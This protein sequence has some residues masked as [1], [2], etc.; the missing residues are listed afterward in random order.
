M[1][2]NCTGIWTPKIWL[3]VLQVAER[4][5]R[6]KDGN[7]CVDYQRDLPLIIVRHKLSLLSRFWAQWL[8]IIC[9]TRWFKY[10]RDWFVCKQAALVPV[11]FEPPC[12]RIQ[13]SP[14]T[15][16]WSQRLSWGIPAVASFLCDNCTVLRDMINGTFC[17]TG[18]IMHTVKSNHRAVTIT[19]VIMHTVKSNHRAVT[20]V[21]LDF[22]LW[23]ER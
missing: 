10:D 23:I 12:T 5:R 4:E 19:G 11:I 9:N 16:P 1:W 17:R 13:L 2:Q 14:L 7:D 8:F 18:V 15:H 22:M 3:S 6:M 20:M 21:T